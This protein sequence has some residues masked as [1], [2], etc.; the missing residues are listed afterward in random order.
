VA[1]RSVRTV[2]FASLGA[3]LASR[4][5]AAI[6]LPESFL[7]SRAGTYVWPFLVDGLLQGGILA[8]AVSGALA[9]LHRISPRVAGGA[10]RRLRSFALTATVMAAV[11]FVTGELFLRV[12]HPEGASFS[13][14]VGPIVRR[15]ERGCRFNAFE[16]PSRGPDD[17]GPRPPGT[18]R[19]LIQ[20]DSV[21]WGQGLPDEADA[22]PS[23]LLAGMRG[24]RPGVEMAVL[25]ACGR[26]IDGHLESLRRHAG[27]IAPDVIIYEW[28]PTDMERPIRHLRPSVTA[29]WTSLFFHAL[30]KQTSWLWFFLDF[31]GKRILNPDLSMEYRDW[32][33]R[34]F[35]DDTPAW[36]AF[37]DEFRAWAAAAKRATP[38]VLVVLYPNVGARGFVL[39]PVHDRMRTL[40]AEAGAE[41][42]DLA[43]GEGLL[44]GDIRR[45]SVSRYDGH[46][47]AAVHEI[48]ADRLLTSI[49]RAW[50]ELFRTDPR[51]SRAQGA[52]EPGRSGPGPW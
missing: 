13:E 18:I 36:R 19:L 23:R 4:A 10:R 39:G 47:N 11:A 16:G 48:I 35:G 33:V 15:F 30:L 32:L 5:L 27:E 44:G 2:L 12:V 37:A 50:P 3:V 22:F 45:V 14:H 9:L 26:E 29:P 1:V 31:H 42:L 17:R 20:G 25:A 28:H 21:A 38:R 24:R 6:P 41:V 8:F 52:G 46:P 40:A 51:S 43:E 49:E 34:Q 7:E